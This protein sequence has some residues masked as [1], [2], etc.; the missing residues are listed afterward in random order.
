MSDNISSAS[1]ALGFSIATFA[2]S[3]NTLT[4]LVRKN[5]L[6]RQEALEAISRARKIV[7]NS[8]GFPGDP[9][10][11]IGARQGMDEIE[12]LFLAETAQQMPSGGH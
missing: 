4:A 2:V 5:I 10:S 8:G 3:V 12:Q 6:S 11:L 7:E 9:D 1:G